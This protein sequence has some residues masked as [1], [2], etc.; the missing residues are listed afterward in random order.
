MEKSKVRLVACPLCARS[1]SV[2]RLK[3]EHCDI[4][5]EGAFSGSKLGLLPPAQ[6]EFVEVFILCGG[7]IKAVEEVLGISYPTVKK[8]LDEVIQ[9]LGQ[10]ALKL[11][12]V[13]NRRDDILKKIETGELSA[14]DGA[15]LLKEI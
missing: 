9:S 7:S 10:D 13:S 8:K 1:L 2:V 14:K 3:C 4:A 12:K 5:I 11:A 6:Q 15:K